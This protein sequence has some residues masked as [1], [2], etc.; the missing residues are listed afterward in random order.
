MFIRVHLETPRTYFYLFLF[1]FFFLFP[2]VTS[3]AHIQ[4]GVYLFLKY[5]Y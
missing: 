5:F 4:E 1:C 3:L 2:P